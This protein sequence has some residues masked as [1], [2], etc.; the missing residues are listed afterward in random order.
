MTV[1]TTLVFSDYTADGSTTAFGL[2]AY[3]QTADQLEVLIDDVVQ[4]D[5]GYV[6][7][8]LRDPGGVTATFSTAPTSGTVRVR[9]V[10][11]LTQGVDT[12]NNEV[13]YQEVFDDALDR[14]V[15]GLQQV[16]EEVSRAIKVEQGDTAPAFPA[17]ADRTAGQYLVWGA[18]GESIIGAAGVTPGEVTVSAYMEGVNALASRTALQKEL[19]VVSFSPLST[20]FG[21]VGDG[22]TDDVVALQACMDYCA[23]IASSGAYRVHMDLGGRAW[24]VIAGPLIGKAGVK[25][26]NGTGL[27]STVAVRANDYASYFA[28]I[29]WEGTLGATACVLD[30]N[31]IPG[32][33]TLVTT[34]SGG[35]LAVD[36]M[37]MIGHSPPV[38]TLSA[39]IN[40]S[41]TTIPVVSTTNFPSAG[42]CLIDSEYMAYRAT[43]ATSITVRATTGRARLGSTA[44]SHSSGAKVVLFNAGH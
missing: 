21:G 7:S 1:A 3:A 8:G 38:T 40:A 36:D 43:T 15:M 24:R 6:I 26:V 20:Q 30:E 11:P 32:S 29:V 39:G 41:D 16:Q 2:A 34:T 12:Q 27:F 28:W 23:S 9:R 14:Q 13:T 17:A 19:A 4:S 22:T 18:D 37:V 10:L 31:T 35:P 5:A 44:T 25:V 42:I 33:Q